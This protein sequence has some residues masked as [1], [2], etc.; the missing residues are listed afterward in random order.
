VSWPG[1]P[2]PPRPTPPGGW[3]TAVLAAAM[4]ELLSDP[5]ALTEHGVGG[6]LVQV[7]GQLAHA[8][9][10]LAA[11]IREQTEEFRRW[12]GEQDA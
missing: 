4:R 5:A 8:I 3:A 2:G 10:A 6:N 7:M 12:R 1:P 9:E 11:A